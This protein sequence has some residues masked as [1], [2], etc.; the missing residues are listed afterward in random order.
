MERSVDSEDAVFGNDENGTDKILVI[1][2]KLASIPNATEV[3]LK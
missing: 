1:L 2:S 3:S